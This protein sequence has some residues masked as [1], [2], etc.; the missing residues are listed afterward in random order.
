MTLSI[1]NDLALPTSGVTQKYAFLGRTGSGKSYA[2]SKL[3]ELLLSLSAQMIVLDPVGIW[4][5]LRV[6]AK[7]GSEA[8]SIP[9]F[10]GLHGDLPLNP[11]SGTL[12]AE[13]LIERN[14]SAVLDVSQF[15]TDGDV[16]RFAIDFADK[17][18][19]LRKAKPSP[20]QLIL[21]ECQDFVPQNPQPGRSDPQYSEP[22]ML[23]R[24]QRIAKQGRNFGIGLSL[25]SQRPQEVNKKVLNQTEC[26]FA[27][28]MTGPQ[29]RKAMKDWISEKGF[30]EDID[31]ILPKLQ[32]G[33]AHVWSPQWLKVSKEIRIAPK[34]TADVSST[35]DF[36]S[37]P[38]KS[39]QLTPVDIEALRD[40]MADTIE[41]AKAD[42]PAELKR[43]I[44][45][46]KKAQKPV[47][48]KEVVKEVP[49]ISPEV[50]AQ[51][52][53][54]SGV[55][56][57]LASILSSLVSKQKTA[58]N[59]TP[60]M[61]RMAA[62]SQVSPIKM[63][64]I[65]QSGPFINTDGSLGKCERALLT[66]LAQHPGGCNRKKLILLAG[67]CWSGSTQNALGKL[68]SIGAVSGGNDGIMQITAAGEHFGPFDPIPDGDQRL[69][70]WLSHP[71]FG[72]C[73]RT[74]LRVLSENPEG[75]DRESL[76]E[77]SG[78]SWSG[79]TQNALGALRSAEV[80]TGRNSEIMK[81]S[82]E[83]LC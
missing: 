17:L 48:P 4:W 75:L 74:L 15:E 10:G 24:F 33:N 55:L 69:A 71:S 77:K 8:F 60:A 42:D 13:L 11:R 78:Y 12:M 67:Y 23:H 58:V 31:A 28:Q 9:V 72:L 40:K 35:P 37:A 22:M 16:R 53:G 79:S 50:V 64:P 2:S 62:R 34:I 63:G 7:S 59:A 81:V 49:L 39:R 25:I 18:F 3:A 80:I 51:L 19:H 45:E 46:L 82:E 32:V 83:I 38:T 20:M 21:E 41:K 54:V 14:L 1:S 29:E 73:E 66:V 36:G 47:A 6:P 44:A 43:Q 27:F 52:V 76:L 65:H 57:E 56:K 26:L 68:R 30:T 61:Q 5:G 70:F